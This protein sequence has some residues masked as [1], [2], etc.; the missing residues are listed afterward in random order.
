MPFIQQGS[1][2]SSTAELLTR[3]YQYDYPEELNLRPGSTLHQKTVDRVMQRVND[4]RRVMEN[5]YKDWDK[6]DQSLT[7]YIPSDLEEKEVKADDERK[8][9]SIVVP[10]SFAIEETFCTYL[11][12]AFLESPI[13]W[14]QGVGP[15]DTL[16]SILMELLVDLQ[17][18]R[19]KVA[20]NLMTFIKDGIR[21]GFG[22]TAPIWKKNYGRKISNESSTSNSSAWREVLF[23]GNA[24]LNV[25]P[26]E[27]LPD[28][29]VPINDVQSGEF[30]GWVSKSN[31]LALL[32]RE[33][34]GEDFFNCKYLRHVSGLSRYAR[35][36][37]LEANTNR[38]MMELS[39]PGTSTKPI[40]V[41]YMYVN[42]IPKEWELGSSEYPEKWLF[43]VASDTVLIRRNR[44]DWNTSC[45]RSLCGHPYSTATRSVRQR[46]W[47]SSAVFRVSL[48]SS[49]TVTSR[50]SGRLS[51]TCSSL[52]LP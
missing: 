21:Y 38:D 4:S 42:L 22:V 36:N 30:T 28:P 33:A 11:A 20:L 31:V 25:D 51:T 16:G 46:P 5:R 7:S 39:N 6:L 34:Q 19:N 47:K 15:E 50:T 52:I 18:N 24:L 9:T 43:A 17:C 10:V 3:D 45:S 8:P 32:D 27:Y 41:I 29:N 40:D 37:S 12:G 13:F 26:R 49:S 23:E 14:Y 2:T 44:W 1:T 35:K 48:I